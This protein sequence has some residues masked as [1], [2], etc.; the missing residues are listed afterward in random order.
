[1]FRTLLNGILVCLCLVGCGPQEDGEGDGP[2]L[3]EYKAAYIEVYETPS[4]TVETIQADAQAQADADA[5]AVPPETEDEP[6]FHDDGP[7]VREPSEA[8]L[9][10]LGDS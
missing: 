6:I 1:M 7:P 3:E 9:A 8:E 2:F 10:A 4:E 5:A